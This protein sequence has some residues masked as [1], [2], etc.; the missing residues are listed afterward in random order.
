MIDSSFQKLKILETEYGSYRD[1][2]RIRLK[3]IIQYEI[4]SMVDPWAGTGSFIPFAELYKKKA[5]FNDLLPVHQIINSAKIINVYLGV[6]DLI[7]TNHKVSNRVFNLL[8]PLLRVKYKISEK[9]ISDDILECFQ[10]AWIKSETFPFELQTFIKAILLL[11]IRDYS[12]F[13]YSSSHGNWIIVG[14]FPRLVD[15]RSS[16]NEKI[17]KF[18]KYYTNYYQGVTEYNKEQYCFF[19]TGNAL[20][21]RIN[22]K[23]D[24]LITSPS[25]RNGTDLNNLY[26]PELDFLSSIGLKYDQ[27]DLIG[28]G[29]VKDY[30][31][32]EFKND[33][34][35]LKDN[36]PLLY[37]F[38]LEA[39]SRQKERSNY[40]PKIFTRHYIR[41]FKSLL[42]FNNLLKKNGKLYL[43]VQDNKHRGLENLMASFI[44]DFYSIKDY[45]TIIYDAQKIP[46]SG[47]RRISRKYPLV[48]DKVEEQIIKI[49]KQ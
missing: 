9:I 42:H 5:F 11:E 1:W 12:N 35:Y 10:N 44:Q 47:N 46:D 4:E 38:I 40:Y 7:F 3:N 2:I 32:I 13:R 25:Y 30:N 45:K 43:C 36:C 22:T 18:E 16:I 24:V 41:L 20:N 37:C 34:N 21:F 49:W 29:I 14:G 17:Q 8:K 19:S 26:F 39:T 6:K 27:I 33:L 23:C 48:K 15:L 31:D 28:T